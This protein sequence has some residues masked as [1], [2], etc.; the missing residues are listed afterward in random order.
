MPTI[1]AFPH[2]DEQYDV[3]DNA[4]PHPV[5]IKGL[6]WPTLTHY[7]HAQKFLNW[8][9]HSRIRSAPS[10]EAAMNLGQ[11][12]VYRL[13]R[14]WKNMRDAVMQ[15]ALWAKVVQHADVRETLLATGEAL[16]VA[17]CPQAYWGDGDS[18]SGM[19]R[20]GALWMAIRAELTKDGP[21]DELAAA[22]LPPWLAHPHIARHS[23]GWRMG[24]GEAYI[25]QWGAW[26]RGLSER[27]R[28]RI[29]E[30]YPEPEEWRGWYL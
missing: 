7:Y 5:L 25:Q 8:Q 6:V 9:H 15:E 28:Q 23:L 24:V 13:R 14:N 20:L 30:R 29:H 27:G 4:S 1:I 12:R 11:S 19:N 21:Y 3:F 2:C 26:Y 22:P 16:I 18:G 17:R 10:A